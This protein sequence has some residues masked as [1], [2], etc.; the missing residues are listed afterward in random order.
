MT[1]LGY[2]L[3]KINEFNHILQ[4]IELE[5]NS[6]IN[7]I[8][9][10]TKSNQ[11]YKIVRYD[12][13]I[14][15]FDLVN[16]YGL[17][18]SVII[19]NMNQVVCFSPPKSMPYDVFVT[20]YADNENMIAEE[21]VEGTMINLFWDPSIGLYGSWE[22]STR[23]T[24][25][26]NISFYKVLHGKTFNTMFMDACTSNHLDI[27]QLNKNYCYSF[28][29]QHP[30]NRIV[31][32]FKSPQLYLVE[33]Y[34]IVLD[35]GT[36][37]VIIYSQNIQS[38]LQYGFQNSSVKIPERYYYNTYDDLKKLYASY[39]TSY[40]ILGFVIKNMETGERCKLRNPVYEEIRRLKGNQ[41]KL[42]YQ[43]L[44]LR[45]QGK[46]S[47]FLKYYPE[48]KKD[49]SKFREQMHSFTNTLYQNYI[50][51]YIKKNKPL[52]DYP[53][54]FRNHMF[55]LHQLYLN[56]LK[57]KKLH[58]TNTVVINYMNGLHP[59]QQMYSLNYHMRKRMVDFIR[60]DNDL[61]EQEQ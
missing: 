51:C 53:A 8:E 7:V 45:H 25:S 35:N 21:F 42:Q 14:L 16:T 52:K 12:K 50:S 55:Q 39:N 46:M 38:Y 30:E 43:Y 26:A 19:N 40:D 33:I 31:V 23:N 4:N 11:K 48:N 54:Q 1:T 29:L 57:E 5:N 27:N 59:S 3:S 61:Q 49:F 10:S 44:S 37:D 2:N 6:K 28:V 32:P 13:E 22:I 58:V 41:P 9:Y 18:R 17:F 47:E 36:N 24:V 56:E 60:A 15:T 20:K 34:E